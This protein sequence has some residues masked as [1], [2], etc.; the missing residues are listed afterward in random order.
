METIKSYNN[1]ELM[2]LFQNKVDCIDVDDLCENFLIGGDG[3][4]VANN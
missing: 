4:D 3:N 1:K 2:E